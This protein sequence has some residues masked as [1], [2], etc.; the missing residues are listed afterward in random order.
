MADPIVSTPTDEP[1][2]DP[3]AEA[4]NAVSEAKALLGC[5]E[6]SLR[7]IHYESD[8]EPDLVAACFGVM[9]I[10]KKVHLDLDPQMFRKAVIASE[11]AGEVSHG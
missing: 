2:E 6:V 1:I 3:I 11:P 5:L 7:E 8:N 9:R 10:L 4:Q